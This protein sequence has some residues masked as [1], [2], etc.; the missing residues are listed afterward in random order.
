[1]SYNIYINNIIDE[2]ASIRESD[3]QLLTIAL[4]KRDQT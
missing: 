3:T 1:M 4:R 2:F